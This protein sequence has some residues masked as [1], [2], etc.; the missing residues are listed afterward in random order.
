MDAE[1][2]QEWTNKA[3]ET[4]QG[5][6]ENTERWDEK[7]RAFAQEKPLLAVLCAVVGGYTLARLTTWR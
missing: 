4:L 6:R 1:I 2:R 5:V 3:S 7:L